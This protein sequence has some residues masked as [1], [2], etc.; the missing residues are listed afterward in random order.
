MREL[1]LL[2]HRIPYPPNKGDKIRS[3]HLLRALSA[4]CRVH[5]GAFVD[6][7]EDWRHAE[8]LREW[9]ADVKLVRLS[10]LSG[11]LRA[12]GGLGGREAVTV[13]L[14]RSSEMRRWVNEKLNAVPCAAVIAFSSAMAQYLP[15]AGFGG[16][17]IVDFVD[18]DSDKWAQYAL[19]AHG[20]LAWLY[21]REARTLLDFERRVAALADA[22]VFVSEAEAQLFRERAPESAPRIH[23]SRNGVDCTYFDPAVALPDPYPS[24]QR[25]I[26]FSGAMDYRAN[27]DAVRW[28][29]TSVLPRVRARDPGAVLY[30]VGARP[31]S[32]VRR[33]ARSDLVIVTGQVPD[34]RP[35]LAHA[36]VAVAPL[37]T[38]RGVQNKVLEAL[39]MN[40]AVVATSAAARGLDD[41]EVPGLTQADSESDFAAA[42][43]RRLLEPRSRS[44][45]GRDYVLRRYD[46]A[47]NLAGVVALALGEASTLE[48]LQG[49]AS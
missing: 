44:P 5:L 46:W 24:A 14:Y 32:A 18:V 1:L 40:C 3:F 36:Q 17:R 41:I 47:R 16:R 23:C 21:R 28:F 43:A 13:R 8:R 39:A 7:G 26:V 49:R 37:R 10:R 42:V 12:L 22:S 2:A 35:Y 6:Q 4:H 45:A 38:A 25:A 33:L 9:C 15:G 34:M 19:T 31:T 30:I 20:P 48:V 27:V 11:S 29:A